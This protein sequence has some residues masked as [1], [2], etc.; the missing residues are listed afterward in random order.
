MTLR[1]N[2]CGDVHLEEDRYFDD[3]VRCLAWFVQGGTRL[4]LSR[5]MDNILT[6]TTF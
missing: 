3:T 6:H 4:L 1:V 2:H 5:L